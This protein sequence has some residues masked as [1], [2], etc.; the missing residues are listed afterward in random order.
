MADLAEVK[1]SLVVSDPTGIVLERDLLPVR[2]GV[3][4]GQ[5]GQHQSLVLATG[6]NSVSIPTGS[7]M[8]LLEL[9][10]NAPPL[11]LKGVNG[12]TGVTIVPNSNPAGVAMLLPLGTSPSMVINNGGG[13][14]YTVDVTFV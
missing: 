14:S 10:S 4:A 13:S 3:G 6:N 2:F 9:T 7:V 1:V 12:D 11:T 5:S 8:M